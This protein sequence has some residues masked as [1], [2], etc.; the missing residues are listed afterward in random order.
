MPLP[1]QRSSRATK[2]ALTVAERNDPT[3]PAILEFQSPST[4]VINMP[5]P[6]SARHTV[7]VIFSWW[8]PS[9]RPPR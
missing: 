8:P 6:R 2:N 7:W 9:S 3:L 5:V 1:P 4:A